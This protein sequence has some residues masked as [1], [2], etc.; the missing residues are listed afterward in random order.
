ML[1]NLEN[2]GKLNDSLFNFISS[3]RDVNTRA[4]IFFYRR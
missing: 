3:H 2:V 1:Q 4:P